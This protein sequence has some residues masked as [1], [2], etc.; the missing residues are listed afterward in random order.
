MVVAATFTVM[1]DDEVAKEASFDLVVPP[2]NGNRRHFSDA[3]RA[4]LSDPRFGGGLGGQCGTCHQRG[5]EGHLARLEL[6]GTLFDPAPMRVKLLLFYLRATCHACG[7]P[8]LVRSAESRAM[9]RAA[10]AFAARARDEYALALTGAKGLRCA[11]C[12]APHASEVR[13]C[14][15]RARARRQPPPTAFTIEVVDAERRIQLVDAERARALAENMATHEE[16]GELMSRFGVTIRPTSLLVRCIAVPAPSNR[17]GEGSEARQD[18]RW[19]RLL[20]HA[21]TLRHATDAAARASALREV[22]RL[23]ELLVVNANKHAAPG[24][25]RPYPSAMGELDGKEGIIRTHVEGHVMDS[26]A[27]RAVAGLDA[28]GEPGWVTVPRWVKKLTVTEAVTV[29]NIDRL[30]REKAALVSITRRRPRQR[31]WQRAHVE[32]TAL[33]LGDSVERCARDGDYAVLMRQ[34]VLR[35]FS[36]M[37]V[38]IRISEDPSLHTILV[39]PCLTVRALCP[40]GAH[41]DSLRFTQPAPTS[42]TVRAR[43]R[44]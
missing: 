2:V 1:D 12:M 40:A 26:Q 16:L 22:Q 15:E 39:H 20:L 4:L 7:C 23:Y 25:F 24:A 30:E 5:C 27:A 21:S 8:Y 6:G 14:R 17:P 43:L 11:R 13:L 35:K 10:D 18:A 31:V 37:A 28:C 36:S 3:C 34:P 44:R 38:Q 32:R 9:R 41:L 29:H 33:A 42:D 19:E